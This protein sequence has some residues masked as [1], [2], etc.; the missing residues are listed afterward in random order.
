MAQSELEKAAIQARNALIPRNIYNDAD[1]NNNY[2]TTHT[3]AKADDVT[4]ENGKGTGVNFDSSNGGSATD[5]NGNPT[6]AGSGRIQ[7]LAKNKF[8]N[9]NEYTTP[10]TTGNVGQVTIA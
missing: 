9:N 10:D 1:P 5:V 3:R 8:N 7:N 4:P 6:F 2:G